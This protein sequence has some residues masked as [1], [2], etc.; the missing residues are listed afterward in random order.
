MIG[1]SAS[2]DSDKLCVSQSFISVTAS[3]ASFWWT[4]LATLNHLLH[5]RGSRVS[6]KGFLQILCHV[7]GWSFPLVIAVTAL[8]FNVLGEGYSSSSGPWCWIKDCEDIKLNPVIWMAITGKFW[9]VLTYLGIFAMYLVLIFLKVKQHCRSR[10]MT[11]LG[12][13]NAGPSYE[14]IPISNYSNDQEPSIDDRF[15]ILWIF[16]YLYVT[17]ISG[18][19]RYFIL[20]VHNG[21]PYLPIVDTIDFVLMYIQSVGD[22]AQAFVNFIGLILIPYLSSKL[23]EKKYNNKRIYSQIM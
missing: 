1:Q 3:L 16:L 11:S 18:T 10:K 15:G 8:S 5:Y 17:R 22:S 21:S 2:C 14:S 12:N 23:Q 7:I 4:F 13:T 20:V 19:V 9:E 6:E